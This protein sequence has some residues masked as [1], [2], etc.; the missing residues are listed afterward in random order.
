MQYYIL[1]KKS[2]NGCHLYTVGGVQLA[3]TF[4]SVYLGIIINSKLGFDKHNIIRG[5]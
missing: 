3:D 1:A 2:Y 4:E 5:Q